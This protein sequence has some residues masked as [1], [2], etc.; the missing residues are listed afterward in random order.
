[1]YMYIHVCSARDIHV[2]VS[3]SFCVS[4]VTR[5]L[6]LVSPDVHAYCDATS[7]MLSILGE[8]E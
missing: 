3:F 5:T 1:M 7:A 8:R 4:W 6:H 2:H